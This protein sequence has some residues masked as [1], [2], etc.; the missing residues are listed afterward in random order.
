[1]I[2][3]RGNAY[4]SFYVLC[5]ANQKRPESFSTPI[6][7]LPVLEPLLYTNAQFMLSLSQ[8]NGQGQRWPAQSGPA[9]RVCCGGE[10]DWPRRGDCACFLVSLKTLSHYLTVDFWP[11]CLFLTLVTVE[12]LLT[13]RNSLTLH[14]NSLVCVIMIR[15]YLCSFIWFT[16]C[17]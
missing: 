5:W 2:S 6:S 4:L 1:M 17:R 12:H 10:E 13:P 16:V 14:H 7:H 11:P 3:E 15:T 8:N 9:C